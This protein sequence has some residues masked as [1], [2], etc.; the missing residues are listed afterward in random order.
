[1]RQFLELL[2]EKKLL[3]EESLTL[4]QIPARL[5]SD[6]AGAYL[7]SIPGCEFRIASGFCGTRN[8]IALSIGTS[9]DNIVRKISGSLRGKGSL[10]QTRH[11]PFLENSTKPDLGKL[12]IP[13]LFKGMKPYLTSSV[14]AANDPEHGPNLS[15]HRMMPTGKKE[16][17]ARIC[18]RHTK[19]YLDRQDPLPIAV[20]IGGHP[21]F[22]IASATTVG[23]EKNEYE[24]ASR[25][26]PT[27]IFTLS[28]GVPVPASSE[29]VLEGT[30]TQKELR[31]EGP[32]VDL[33]ATYDIERRQPVIRLEKMHYRS[34]PIMHLIVPSLPEHALLM[35]MP[36]EPVI[37][38]EVSKVA[39]CR[40]VS[41][42]PG[43]CNWLHG[44]VSIRKRTDGEIPKVIAAAFRGH[45]SMKHLF[46]VDDD[47]DIHNPEEIEWALATRFQGDRMEVF[48]DRGS[49][50][51]PSSDI[52][53]RQ[54]S[55][56]AFDCTIPTSKDKNQFRKA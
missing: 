46:I 37:L 16:L 17:T 56:I 40:G 39:D 55:K 4:K 19:A 11:A 9:R 32:F 31:P 48:R 33:T 18:D 3:K 49:S 23:I 22:L 8:K 54:T 25:L 12:P 34:S 7:F 21:S 41:L 42:T 15:F 29:I 13:V 47:I 43:G 44:A 50:L 51:D 28:N 26:H 10:R 24:I 5:K 45:P 1:V 38:S 27:E 36:R 6:P 14:I 35:G 53:S 20:V 30:L 2:K 52:K